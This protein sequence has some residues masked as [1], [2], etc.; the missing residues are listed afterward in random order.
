MQ[1]RQTAADLQRSWSDTEE[2]SRETAD[3]AASDT[4]GRGR[5]VGD[6]DSPATPIDLS[7]SSVGASAAKPRQSQ[8]ALKFGISSILGDRLVETSG[9]QDVDASAPDDVQEEAERRSCGCSVA[10]DSGFAQAIV[11]SSSPLPPPKPPLQA[12][13]PQPPTNP[14]AAMSSLL[15]CQAAAAAAAAAAASMPPW[16]PAHSAA[17]LFGV[18]PHYGAFLHR[19]HHQLQH[20]L[21]EQHHLQR[22]QQ[23]QQQQQQQP[24][25]QQSD[26]HFINN[27]NGIRNPLVETHAAA[28][29]SQRDNF[30]HNFAAPALASSG[31]QAA[32]DADFECRI[33]GKRFSLQRLLNRHLKCHSTLKRYLCRYCG[34]GFNDTFDLKR[35]TRTHTGV[36]PYKC[37]DCGKAFTQRCSLESHSKKVHHRV[38]TYAHKE[39]RE[40][41][42]VCEDCG[43]TTKS[44]EEHY[45]HVKLHHQQRQPGDSAKAASCSPSPPQPPP[46]SQLKLPPH[47]PAQ[48]LPGYPPM[49]RQLPG[50]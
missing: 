37:E 32:S 8:T 16:L 24:P 15:Q 26:M 28:K 48:L 38:F 33:C 30:M 27:G 49:F 41:L 20:Q 10:E 11:S 18:M 1:L 7:G 42:H 35:H 39:R 25:S 3:E 14:A 5:G 23:Q 34:K 2:E 44:A 21:H 40:K 47:H 43:H 46:H 12:Q 4:R 22:H 19:P 9:R 45:H 13:L 31:D 6:R 36:R 17:A 29:I 50:L